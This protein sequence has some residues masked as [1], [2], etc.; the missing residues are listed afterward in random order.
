[1]D[2]N[3]I[4]KEAR[5]V[6]I[7]FLIVGS[8]FAVIGFFWMKLPLKIRITGVKTTATISDINLRSTL[9]EKK[10]YDVNIK[11]YV[12]GRSYGGL[13]DYYYTGMYIGQEVNVYYNPEHPGEFVTTGDVIMIGMF[14]LMGLIGAVCGFIVIIFP[15]KTVRNNENNLIKKEMSD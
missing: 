4:K 13:L 9:D 8:L 12:D 6:G 7:I 15:G 10:E 2:E 14:F 5:K 1:M 3:E 11:Y